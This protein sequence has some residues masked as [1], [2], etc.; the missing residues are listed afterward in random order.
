[1]TRLPPISDF[2]KTFRTSRDI[3]VA[4]ERNA[5]THWRGALASSLAVSLLVALSYA[6][7]HLSGLRLLR[8]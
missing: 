7:N 8:F 2:K 4:K 1:M 3:R 6:F 5:G